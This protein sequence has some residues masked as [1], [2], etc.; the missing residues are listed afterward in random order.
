MHGQNLFLPSFLLIFI[1]KSHKRNLPDL[2]YDI[3]FVLLQDLT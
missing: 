1:V 3:D 2:S